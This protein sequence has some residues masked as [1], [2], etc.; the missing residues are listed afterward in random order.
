[1]PTI[2]CGLLLILLMPPAYAA[3]PL[4]DSA[5]GKR[6]F[7][8]NC[9]GCHDTSVLARKVRVV[10]SLDALKEQLASCTHMA[11]KELP[12]SDT[13]DLLKYLNDQFYR[14]R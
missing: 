5:N 4:G 11:N 6:L 12:A 3:S 13:Q 1:M 10:K 9:A 7:D 14:F 8:A 2:V